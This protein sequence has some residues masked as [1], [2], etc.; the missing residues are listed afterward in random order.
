M[1]S[2]LCSL[3]D[4]MCTMGHHGRLFHS[5]HHAVLFSWCVCVCLGFGERHERVAEYSPKLVMVKEGRIM[6]VVLQVDKIRNLD[7]FGNW[8]QDVL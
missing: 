6:E 2:P 3:N 7:D 4:F 1:H 8:F 5:H